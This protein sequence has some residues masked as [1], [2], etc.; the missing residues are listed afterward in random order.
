ML[1]SPSTLVSVFFGSLIHPGTS[2]RPVQRTP[3]LRSC[4]RCS[5]PKNHPRFPPCDDGNLPR[6]FTEPTAVSARARPD[7]GCSGSRVREYR[8]HHSAASRETGGNAQVQQKKT[9]S[10]LKHRFLPGSP[11]M[12][13]NLVRRKK[14]VPTLACARPLLAEPDCRDELVRISRCPP[15]ASQLLSQAPRMPA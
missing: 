10:D 14:K 1:V 3:L 13:Q 7:R 2:H 8:S 5:S 12:P 9:R 6:G 4:G 15:T 11:G